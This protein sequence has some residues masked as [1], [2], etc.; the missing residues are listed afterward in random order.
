MFVFMVNEAT[1]KPGSPVDQ[2]L[3]DAW[4]NSVSARYEDMSPEAKRSLSA[5]RTEWTALRVA[6]VLISEKQ[7]EQL[8]SQWREQ[9]AVGT[10]ET[11]P[12]Q[13]GGGEAA[14]S[15]YSGGN[16]SSSSSQDAA[17]RYR[18]QQEVKRITNDAIGNT[19]RMNYNR[20]GNIGSSSWRYKN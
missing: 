16:S 20:I 11:V 10:P 7:R 8:R 19:Y 14:A 4:S 17:A 2:R 6:W 15:G 5:A 12:A 18:S 9:L 13:A 3:K 1:G